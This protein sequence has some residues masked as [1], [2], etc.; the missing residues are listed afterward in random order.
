VVLRISSM[1]EDALSGGSPGGSEVRGR[2][3][4]PGRPGRRGQVPAHR[5][6]K[7]TGQ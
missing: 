6:R 1:L 7:E 3:H 4:S 5:S 2:A